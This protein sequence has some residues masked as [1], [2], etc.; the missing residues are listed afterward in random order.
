[1]N[2]CGFTDADWVGSSTEKKSTSGGTF[3]IGLKTVSWYS[4]RQRSMAL[5]SAEA[6]YM[7]ASL[8]ACEAIW[9][10]KVL[11]GL[12]GSYLQPT[13]IYCDNQ[14]CIKLSANLVFHDRFKHIDIRYHHITNCVQWRIML[15]SYISTED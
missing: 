5:S 9:M 8:D 15:L 11:V 2:L 4:R 13:M 3:S 10:R 6:K 12:L 1:M 7:A 14:S